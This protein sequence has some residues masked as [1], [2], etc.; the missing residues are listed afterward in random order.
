MRKWVL[1]IA[2]LGLLAAGV[3]LGYI[4]LWKEEA[5]MAVA[6]RTTSV[7]RGDLKVTVAGSGVVAVV[8][9]KQALAPEEGQLEALQVKKGELVEAGQVIAAY[10][11][12]DHSAEIKKL[13]T[14][15]A[16]QEMEFDKLKT[17]YIE[18]EESARQSVSYEIESL[19]LDIAANK[20]SLAELNEEEATVTTIT[21]PI[22]G[23]V[24]TIHIDEAGQK[25]Q[26]GAA[27]ITITDYTELQSVIQ[28]DE[29]D[30]TKVKLGQK[31]EV[32]LDAFEE[33]KIEGTVTEIAD[34]GSSQN[35]VALFD[36]TIQFPTQDGIR[37][38]M[39]ASAEITVESKQDVL[40]VPIEAIREAGSQ[41]MVLLSSSA[42]VSGGDNAG[43]TEVND[44]QRPG[45]SQ[46]G[47]QEENRTESPASNAGAGGGAQVAD[48]ENPSQGMPRRQGGSQGQGGAAAGGGARADNGMMRIVTVGVSN[49]T[50]IEILSGLEEGEQV[51][52]PTIISSTTQTNMTGFPGAGGGV[53]GGGSTPGGSLGGGGGGMQRS[54][55]GGSSQRGG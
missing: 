26:S 7:V 23:K 3:Y 22:T 31:A 24:T 55:S 6:V 17:K 14:S 30:V 45:M 47:S 10:E 38:G 4:Y 54:S 32:A 37:I 5:A 44:R 48:D 28:V 15:L 13:Q 34:E 33:M 2:G 16:K 52:L 29:L 50:Y 12:T 41:K 9:T 51:I 43:N 42:A 20:Q 39:S 36:V 18:A 11:A 49:E 25:V 40:M 19:K 27:I 21:A 35:G 1:A 53:F 46:G 8:N